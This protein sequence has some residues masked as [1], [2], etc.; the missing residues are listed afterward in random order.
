MRDFCAGSWQPECPPVAFF[1]VGLI[2]EAILDRFWLQCNVYFRMKSV[3]I[4]YTF[5]QGFVKHFRKHLC[6][7]P[8]A[9]TLKLIAISCSDPRRWVAT[10]LESL[11]SSR[12]SPWAP[13]APPR[14][15]LGHPRPLVG[16]PWLLLGPCWPTL[17]PSW[18]LLGSLLGSP[19][20]LYWLPL[21]H[22]AGP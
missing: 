18:F 4:G 2:F 19:W 13:A 3:Q 5:L 17:G 14:A 21:A 8:G 1:F 15:P 20:L 22:L 12:P 6:C 7:F 16:L 10:P 11:S 9:P